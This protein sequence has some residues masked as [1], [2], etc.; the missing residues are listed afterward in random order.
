M[1]EPKKSAVGAGVDHHVTRNEP[2][3]LGGSNDDG[4]GDSSEQHSL[5]VARHI[6]QDA[7]TSHEQNPITLIDFGS[8]RLEL[9]AK[10]AVVC[11]GVRVGELGV[12]RR[13]ELRRVYRQLQISS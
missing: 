1:R 7:V 12:L 9:Q 8:S 2:E 4:D 13:Y 10:R 5:G 3:N 11:A 6:P